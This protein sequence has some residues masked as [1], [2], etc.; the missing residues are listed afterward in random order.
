MSKELDNPINWSFGIGSLFGIRLRVHLLFIFGGLI[1]VFNELRDGGGWTGVG[2][3]LGTLGI[4][5]LIVLLHEFGHCFG[6]RSVGGTADEILMWPLGGLAFTS[7]P[8]NP[9]AHLVTVIAGPAVNVALLMITTT[10]LVTWKGTVDTLPLNPFRPFATNLDYFP[11]GLHHWLVV[12]FTLNLIILLFNLAPVFPFDG[13]R[14]LQCI[15]WFHLDFVRA[16]MIATGVGM[17]GAIVIGVVG[18]ATEEVMFFAIA[19]FGYFTCWQQRQMLKSGA[20]DTGNEFG[21]DFSQGY[22]SLEKGNEGTEKGPSF[23]ERRRAR[24][25]ADQSQR[26]AHEREEQQHEVD[27][28]LNKVHASGIKSL[29]GKERRLLEQET[30]RQ[31][32]KR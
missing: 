10:V 31:R 3:G 6:A 7:P 23:L 21:Y 2:Y 1:V 16:T 28:I 30:E 5:F 13:G 12:F 4:L 27:R 22:T 25:A 32:S 26:E 29:T 20:Y 24:R 8:H 18:L 11:T 14:V 9:R 15:L 19:F 17:V